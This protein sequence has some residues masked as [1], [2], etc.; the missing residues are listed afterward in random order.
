MKHTSASTI[1]TMDNSGLTIVR[2]SL[3]FTPSATGWVDFDLNTPFIWNG[4]DNILVEFTHNAGNGGNGSG[5][6]TLTTTT[7]TNM[8]FYGASD[9]RAG[10]I[11]GFWSLT[12][13]SASGATTSRPNVR[14]TQNS[15][16]SKTWSPATGLYTDAGGTMAYNGL[17]NA[18]TIYA[19]PSSTQSYTVT[20]TSALGCTSTASINVVIEGTTVTSTADA[21]PG[22]LRAALNCVVD[23][24]T[25][26]YDQPATATTVLTAPLTID[27]NVTIM[28]ASSSSR[29][30]ITTSTSGISI[31]VDKTLILKDVDVKSTAPTQTFTG[32][33]AVSITGMTVGKQ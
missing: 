5:T 9:S 26:M 30:E 19:S 27:K 4:T 17:D 24:G 16:I 13:F 29:P 15:S 33:G 25:I 10:G 2:D 31:N 14:F 8:T 20:S 7:A 3:T 21:G 18:P 22:T 28:G 23:G 1:S 12:S 32:A 6:R 11:G